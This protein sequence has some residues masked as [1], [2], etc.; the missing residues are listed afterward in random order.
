M[1]LDI[2]SM[3]K[4]IRKNGERLESITIRGDKEDF[5]AFRAICK[6]NGVTASALIRQFIHNVIEEDKKNSKN[7]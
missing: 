4:P 7:A 2:K 5:A 3:V 6:K 1:E